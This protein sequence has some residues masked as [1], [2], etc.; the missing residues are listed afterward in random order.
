MAILG[1]CISKT[2]QWV[3]VHQVCMFCSISLLA[4]DNN[5]SRERCVPSNKQ[6]Q[7]SEHCPL[8]MHVQIPLLVLPEDHIGPNHNTLAVHLLFMFLLHFFLFYSHPHLFSSALSFF[9]LYSTV[10]P[11]HSNPNTKSFFW[12]KMMENKPLVMSCSMCSAREQSYSLR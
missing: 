6:N 8:C 10:P 11:H 9:C 3:L 7:M 1:H 5:A 12:M 2:E 4:E